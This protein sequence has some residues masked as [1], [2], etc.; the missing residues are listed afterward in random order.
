MI[1]RRAFIVGGLAALTAPLAAGAQQVGKVWR[2]GLLVPG[3]PPGCGSDSQP[4]PLVALRDGLRELG[5][6]E[7]QNYVFVPRCA[8]REGEEMLSAARD[9]VG[10][11][12]DVVMVGSNELAEALKKATTTVPVVFVAVADPEE[13]GLVASLARPG[14]N[15]T[16]F[17][18]LTGEL[19]GK[20]LQLLKDALPRLRRVAA[21]A[22]QKHRS[23]AKPPAWVCR[24][25]SSSPSSR[26]RSA[27]P[28][29][30]RAPS[31]R[32]PCSSIP[33]RCSGWSAG[34]SRSS[35]RRSAS[36]RF[37]R[38]RTS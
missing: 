38:A 11:N 15:I 5:H 19:T 16:G 17:S 23:S 6:V 8:V 18:H 3:L 37:T 36:P 7:T 26:A 9:L 1:D 24:S 21:L 22:T 27:R 25:S 35:P 14:G 20:R 4:P 32:R 13:S 2:I 29:R 10:Q 28:S 34:A 30:Q 31:G 12:V 33:I